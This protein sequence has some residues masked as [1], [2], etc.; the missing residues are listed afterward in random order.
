MKAVPEWGFSIH[1]T[2]LCHNKY[3][4]STECWNFFLY[5][6]MAA[7]CILQSLI[8]PPRNAQE[9][10]ATKPKLSCHTGDEKR[11][12]YLVNRKLIPHLRTDSS[13]KCKGKALCM[14]LTNSFAQLPKG[15]VPAKIK[16]QVTLTC[17][18]FDARTLK[19]TG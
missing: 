11:T 1:Q 6:P 14:C 17:E 19:K 8:Y 9:S 18:C 10:M 2:S 12:L 4:P 7:K 13:I 3:K 16:L 15:K 5:N